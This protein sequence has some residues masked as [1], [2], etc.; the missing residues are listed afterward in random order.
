MTFKIKGYKIFIASPS[1]LEEERKAFAALIEEYNKDE[2]MHREV[3]FQ[4]VGWEE[5]LSGMGRPQSLINEELRKCDYFVL[6]LHDRWGSFPGKNDKAATSGTEEEYII[7]LDCYKSKQHPMRQLICFFKSVP[8]NQLADPG[9]E[10]QKVLDFK[11]KLETK[12]SLLYS[13]FS[14]L[15]EFNQLL[16]KNLSSGTLRNSIINGIYHPV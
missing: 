2:A 8:P 6:L 15:S 11:K 12:K 7:S 10:L 9:K 13:T 5:T 14:S 3:I 1:G 4:A 16:R